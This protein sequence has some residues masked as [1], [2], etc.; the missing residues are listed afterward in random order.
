M[1]AEAAFLYKLGTR[2]SGLLE[3]FIDF[4]VW[5]EKNIRKGKLLIAFTAINQRKLN[6]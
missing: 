5:L 3:F 2:V 6:F 1:W 4:S